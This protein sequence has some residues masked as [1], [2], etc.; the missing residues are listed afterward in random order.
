MEISSD[1]DEIAQV[2]SDVDNLAEKI[3]QKHFD[4]KVQPEPTICQRCDIRHLCK[5]EGILQI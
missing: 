4:V 5:K 1:Q 3:Q 2:V